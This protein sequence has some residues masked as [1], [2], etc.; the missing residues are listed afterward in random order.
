MGDGGD[1]GPVLRRAT[2]TLLSLSAL[3]AWA[4]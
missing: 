2:F 1:R 3:G 4:P